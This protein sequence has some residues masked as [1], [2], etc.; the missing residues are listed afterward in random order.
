M[1]LGMAL[2]I[3]GML[4]VAIS[5]TYPALFAALMLTGASKIVF[6]SS[7][8]AYIGDR[9]PYARRGLAIALT[10]FGWSGAFLLGVPIIGWLIAR[11]GWNSPF[12]WL[13]VFGVAVTYWLWRIIPA[14]STHK[15]ERLSLA[16][17]L[18]LI[19][20]HRAAVAGLALA[21][22]IS[23]SNEIVNIVFGVWLNDKFELQVEALGVS[24]IV[25]GVAE[26]LGEGLVGVFS[27]RLGKRRTVGAGL[28]MYSL[29]CLTL[30]LLGA[31]VEGAL[32]GLFLFFLGFEFTLVSV[33]PLMTELVPSARATLLSANLTV[34][35]LGR[36]VGATVGNQ[37]YGQHSLLVNSFVA[38]GLN[39]VGLAVLI[40][41]VREAAHGQDN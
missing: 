3:I 9:V 20:T 8:Q 4:L 2:F 40:L 14:D 26:L 5:P 23:G 16:Q 32:T 21:A 34:F 17:G 10:E 31:T 6:D 1:L 33:I 12:L 7:M 30:P 11:S 27:D 24:V 36:A 22:L 19:L 18:R 15:A 38:A 35:S 37:L 28:V 13:T 25:I 29:A 41:F 39:L